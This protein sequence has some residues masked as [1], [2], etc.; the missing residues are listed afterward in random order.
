MFCPIS[1][2]LVHQC[3]AIQ[4]Q[5]DVLNEDFRRILGSNG[6]NTHPDGADTQIEFCLAQRRPDGSAFA[7]GEPGVN[8]VN[9]TTI[10]ATAPPYSTAQIN[11]TIKTWTYN[12][13]VPTATRGWDPNKYMNIWLCDISGGILGYAQFP[14]SPLGGM[15][16]GTPA[17]ATDGVVFLYSSIGKSSVTGFPGTLQ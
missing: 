1:F 14:Q 15:G 12:G 8:R 11:S 7:I 6:W 16:C 17:T 2:E 4:S 9:Y 5:I 3:K 10:T 13:G